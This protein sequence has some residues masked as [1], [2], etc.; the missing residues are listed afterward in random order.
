[1]KVQRKARM[2]VSLT[3][4]ILFIFVSSSFAQLSNLYNFDSRRP[5]IIDTSSH[6][7]LTSFVFGNVRDDRSSLEFRSRYTW[8]NIGE[9]TVVA[10][11][12]VMLKY[13]PFNRPLRGSR[14]VVPGHT[15]AN[16]SHLRP[17]QSDSDASISLGSE[18]VF[19]G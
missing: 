3:F 7:E 5:V 8:K 4:V 12:I 18:N 15:S 10:F 13:D 14:M 6:I 9:Q 17:G 1:M 19:T 11:E 16:W 2:C